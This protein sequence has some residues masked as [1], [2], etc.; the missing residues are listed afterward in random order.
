MVQMVQG[1]IVERFIGFFLAEHSLRWK[2][3]L[4]SCALAAAWA[5]TRL[6]LSHSSDEEVSFEAI[7][8]LCSLIA[9]SLFVYV[10]KGRIFPANATNPRWSPRLTLRLGLLGSAS[11]AL[12]VCMSAVDI[13]K[14]QAGIADFRLKSFTTFLDTVQAANLPEVQIRDRY[15]RIQSIVSASSANQIPVDFAVLQGAQRAVSS[16]LKTRSLSE[17][18]EQ[19]GLTTSI[20]LGSLAYT[21]QVQ[22]G[23]I[24]PIAPRQIANSGG[25]MLASPVFLRNDIYV[26]GEHSWIALAPSGGQFVVE[27]ST[28]VFDKIDFLGSYITGTPILLAGERANAM[29]RDS[30]IQ[31][32]D[33]PLDR[34]TWV[35]VR[36][37]ASRIRYTEGAPLR[38]RNVS[39]KGCDLTPIGVPPAWGPISN[40]LK[41]RINEADGQPITFVY[42]P[43]PK[44]ENP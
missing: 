19:L 40:R 1:K 39:F 10:A 30:I 29:V 13:P 22:T 21:R 7:V 28:V 36:F 25:L 27:Q 24:V 15:K 14:M 5:L 44:S 43:R 31:A 3:Y 33:E 32:A 6:S 35:D 20:D 42:E 9:V 18:T 41:Q 16:S 11:L 17:Q 4:T 12:V 38:L 34:I 37:E 26:R 8:I 2:V 23:A